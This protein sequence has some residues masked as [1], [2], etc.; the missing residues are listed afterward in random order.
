MFAALIRVDEIVRLPS[1]R[2]GR[3]EDYNGEAVEGVYLDNG[4]PWQLSPKLL[5]HV[6]S[7]LAGGHLA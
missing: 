6:S 5:I 1:G 2:L 7:K 3:I 4:E